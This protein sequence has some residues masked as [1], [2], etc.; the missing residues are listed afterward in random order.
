MLARA[1]VW[2]GLQRKVRRP[3]DFV[4]VFE[5]CKVNE[6]QDNVVVREAKVKPMEGRPGRT[7]KETCKM[8][9]PTK[10]RQVPWRF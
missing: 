1:Q 7:Q 6:E 4:P 5:D 3:H 10:V 9:A 2:A 8:Y